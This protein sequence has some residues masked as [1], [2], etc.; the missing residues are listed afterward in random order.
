MINASDNRAQG[1]LH[2][3]FY[4]R[5]RLLNGDPFRVTVTE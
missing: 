1:G 3:H 4:A 5:E 2:S